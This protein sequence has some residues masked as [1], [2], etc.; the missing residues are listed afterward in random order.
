MLLKHGCSQELWGVKRL[1]YIPLGLVCLNHTVYGLNTAV[2][3]MPLSGWQVQL[4]E[5]SMYNIN[6]L[7]GLQFAFSD[8][9]KP[10]SPLHWRCTALCSALAP[11]SVQLCIIK[12]WQ[13]VPSQIEK[14]LLNDVQIS[15]VAYWSPAWK[16]GQ[17]WI[18]MA[19]LAA[20]AH[21]PLV[22]WNCLWLSLHFLG[23]F[24]D[25]QQAGSV[26]GIKGLHRAESW[27]DK[28]ALPS[29]NLGS[30]TS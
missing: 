29:G 28:Y 27:F 18:W 30:D 25:K 23:C 24:I 7:A 26:E 1:N 2:G 8:L 11:V 20:C 21:V 10:F 19:K 6:R 3:S 16:Q 9:V 17:K 4:V 15:D 22:F 13:C 5:V 14:K 12:C